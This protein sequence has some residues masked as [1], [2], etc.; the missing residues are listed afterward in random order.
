MLQF[1]NDEEAEENRNALFFF[2]FLTLVF[3]TSLNVS[4]YT[5]S[6]HVL[7]CY[8]N[9]SQYRTKGMWETAALSSSSSPC[10]LACLA[11]PLQSSHVCS[12]VKCFLSSSEAPHCRER[13]LVPSF[14]SCATGCNC[15]STNASIRWLSQQSVFTLVLLQFENVHRQTDAAMVSTLTALQ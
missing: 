9:N 4:T 14:F 1:K 8:V 11:C 6:L 2:C 10:V 15:A 13:L 5:L 12:R 7:L 3:K